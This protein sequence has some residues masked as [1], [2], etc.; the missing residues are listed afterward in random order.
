[1]GQ[2]KLTVVAIGHCKIRNITCQQYAA[3]K[4]IRNTFY[5]CRKTKTI[6]SLDSIGIVVNVDRPR[7]F[8]SVPP[9][10]ITK[11]HT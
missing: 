5:G 9:P 10:R 6:Q 3:L 8:N 1:M 4:H 11:K 7:I 2:A